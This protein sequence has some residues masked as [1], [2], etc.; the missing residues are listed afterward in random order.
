MKIDWDKL[1]AMLPV[2]AYEYAHQGNPLADIDY[3]YWRPHEHKGE[4]PPPGW[5]NIEYD[6]SYENLMKALSDYLNL[7][8]TEK[9]VWY[10]N[11]N[12]EFSNSW[13]YDVN[14]KTIMSALTEQLDGGFPEWKLII[15]RCE[16]DVNFEFMYLMKIVTNVKN[17]K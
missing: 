4:T 11:A 10:N 17:P 1:R 3:S 6:E 2:Y 15:Y 5:S 13:P 9:A 14:D 8:P 7:A 16:S 12:G